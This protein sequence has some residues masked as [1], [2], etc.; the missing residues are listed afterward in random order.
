ME[1]FKFFIYQG[2]KFLESKQS[3]EMLKII[4]KKKIEEQLKKEENYMTLY[5]TVKQ[6]IAFTHKNK[7]DAI[8]T[9]NTNKCYYRQL[10]YFDEEKGAY[11]YVSEYPKGKE[12]IY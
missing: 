1:E 11:R 3:R 7:D 5:A 9:L 10:W 2:E 4:E 12:I 8:N 6:I